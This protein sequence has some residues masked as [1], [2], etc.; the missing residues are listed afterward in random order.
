[1]ADDKFDD[2]FKAFGKYAD[3]VAKAFATNLSVDRWNQQI[4]EMETSAVSLMKTFGTGRDRI[5][6][7]KQ[8]MADA[9]KDVKLLGGEFSD[10]LDIAQNVGVGLKRNIILTKDAY[11]DLYATSKATGQ[12]YQELTKNFTDAGYSIYQINQN[13]QKVVDSARTSGI[14]VKEV[15]SQV[16]SNLSMMDKYN[17]SNGVEGLGKM[18]TQATNLKISVNSI[19]TSMAKAFKPG[20]SYSNGG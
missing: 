7:M 12:G 14:N 5:V 1:M 16:L 6:E 18:V 20:R 11:K 9:S 15:S 10:V 8:S 19:E 3:M 17:F 2:V 13:M 4:K